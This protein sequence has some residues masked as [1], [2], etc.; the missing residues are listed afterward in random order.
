MQLSLV[1]SGYQHVMRRAEPGLTGAGERAT[2]KFSVPEAS[3]SDFGMPWLEAGET[4]FGA[5]G[6]SAERQLGARRARVALARPKV[7]EARAAVPSEERG[8]PNDSVDSDQQVAQAITS[9]VQASGSGGP[10]GAGTGSGA[11][12][13]SEAGS[14][15]PTGR[16]ARGMP[17]HGVRGGT[18]SASPDSAFSDYF[19]R[20]RAHLDPFWE[21]AF[22]HSEVL[23]GRG[24]WAIVDLV[25][26]PDGAVSGA[27]LIRSSGIP[28][29]DRNLLAAVIR[30]APFPAM[31]KMLSERPLPF[32]ITFD[33]VN[34]AVSPPR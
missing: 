10:S 11:V 2:A 26:H 4:R 5:S 31:P 1:V 16:G 9:M 20:V 27:R 25:I 17:R 24:G 14:G 34:P 6:S 21:N 22:P 32:R 8:R 3:L 23:A 12:A 30:A 13:E 33:E 15:A 18:Y 7:T 19:Y 29:F 28:A